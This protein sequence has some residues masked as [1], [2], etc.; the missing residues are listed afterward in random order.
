MRLTRL[1]YCN[2]STPGT[3]YPTADG[4]FQFADDALP[5]GI[6]PSGQ[7]TAS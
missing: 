3:A 2:L 4:A 7:R 5:S 1:A 6:F